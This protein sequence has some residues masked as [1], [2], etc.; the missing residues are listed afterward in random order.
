MPSERSGINVLGLVTFCMILGYTIP[1]MDKHG[2]VLLE[3]IEAVNEASIKLVEYIMWF[4]PIGI[5]SLVCSSVLNMENPVAV[6]E[7]IS[8]Y[9]MT[10]LIG[11]F[12]HGLIILPG[13][14]LI[15]TRKNI[16]LYAKNMIEAM[17]IAVATSSRY[18]LV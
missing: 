1:K 6:F 7:K 17:L 15:V 3:F 2:K 16:L 4:S 10:V 8:Y 12:L 18:N 13:I 11:L 14:Y 9:M 5:C